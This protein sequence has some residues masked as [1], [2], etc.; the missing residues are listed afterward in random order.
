[1]WTECGG[2]AHRLSLT[3]QLRHLVAELPEYVV[4]GCQLHLIHVVK[5]LC[6]HTHKY[7]IPLT[8]II[9]YRNTD[10]G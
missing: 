1:M 4:Q 8:L 7:D 3:L 6:G 2:S 5:G 9:K 10:E